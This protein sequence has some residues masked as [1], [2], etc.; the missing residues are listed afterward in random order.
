MVLHKS[1]QRKLR[2]GQKLFAAIVLL[3]SCLTG[4]SQTNSFFQFVQAQSE[5]RYSNVPHEVLALWYGWFGQPENDGWKRVEA[6]KTVE[7]TAHHPV[8]GSYSSHDA[9]IIDWQIDQAKAHGITG[10]VVSWLGKASRWHDDSLAL[11]IERAEKKN[12][13]ISVY[14]EQNRD[15]GRYMVQ[16]SVDDLTYILKRYGTSKAFL[17]LN[18]KP[19]IF[20]YERVESQAPLASLMEI[21]QKTRA[22]AGDFILIGQG[23]EPS[24]AMFFDGLHTSYANMHLDLLANS[25]PDK[26]NQFEANAAQIFNEGA[27]LTRQHSH[28]V[29]PMII[30]GFDNTK[31]SPAQVVAQRY[32]GQTYRILWEKALETNPDWILISSWNEWAEG[33]EIEPSLETKDQYLQITA[34]YAKRF[35][36]SRT[37]NVSSTKEPPAFCPGTKDEIY[38]VLKGQSVAILLTGGYYDAEFWADYLGATVQRL[39]WN[40][41]IDTKKFNASIFPVFIVVSDE[42]YRSSIKVTDDVSSS[43]IR[44]FHQGG[45]LVS[46]PVGTWPFLYDDSRKGIPRGITDTLDLGID[47][48]FDQPPSGS[49]L[50]FYVNRKALLGLPS[51]VPFPTNGDLRFRPINHSRVSPYDFY[52]PLVQLWDGQRHFEGDA[53]A[54]VEHR[55]SALSPGKSIYVW[56]RT[57]EALGPDEFYPSLYQFISTKLKPSP[58]SN[59]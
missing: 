59:P 57:A 3:C 47:N 49:D 12:F 7:I 46:L 2:C 31:S 9:S 15:T 21:L 40:D 33:T 55:A 54:Y 18:G 14:W 5:R 25:R 22:N 4:F 51:P 1:K 41:L 48:G 39:S 53:A 26:I 37:V 32:D 44:Y 19:V 20:T 11:L 29:C 23:Y 50:K 17:K 30:P 24:L 52:Q 35:L 42:H 38:N 8:K 34:E 13:K 36:A 10:F 56:M 6:N 16:F 28:I 58:A 27:Q 43:L 45:F